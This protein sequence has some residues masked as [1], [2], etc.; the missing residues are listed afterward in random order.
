MEESPS[1]KE[2]KKEEP[3]LID[4]NKKE[5]SENKILSKEK[6]RK[7]IIICLS[8]AL[9]II[10]L[11]SILAAR[12]AHKNKIKKKESKNTN[13]TSNILYLKYYNSELKEYKLFDSGKNNIS[14]FI[15]TIKIDGKK[16]NYIE[17]YN[18]P[19]IGEHIVEI[20][21]NTKISSLNRLFKDCESLIDVDFSYFNNENVKDLAELF[22][23]CISLISVNFTNFDTSKV[24][25][26]SYM[27][28]NCNKL[29]NI[30]LN[31]FNTSNT[32][33]MSGMFK[34]CEILEILNLSNFNGK[35]ILNISSM[36]YKC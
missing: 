6:E 9:S 22:S 32:I 3:L 36:F 18:F 2:N 17:K 30:D 13:C 4:Q 5:N 31:N 21:L 12:S 16:I 34:N 8:I 20:R 11:C 28:Y 1:N 27:F 35:E 14:S 19:K 15:Q 29:K 33:D 25:N 23:G 26:M 24:K 7:N 10:F